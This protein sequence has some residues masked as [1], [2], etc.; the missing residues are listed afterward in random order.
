MIAQHQEREVL[1]VFDG[2]I[3]VDE[4]YFGGARKGQR[5]RGS[6]GKVP[7]FGLLKRG[8]KVHTQ[9]IPDAKR[10]PLVPIIRSKGVT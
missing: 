7:V 3:E 9:V 4:S 5:E 1:S 10:T 2:E 6:V 8:C